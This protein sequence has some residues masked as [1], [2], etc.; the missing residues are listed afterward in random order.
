MET[1]IADFML[2]NAYLAA[3]R[4]ET[5]DTVYRLT[6]SKTVAKDFSYMDG[7][8][9]EWIENSY[10][11]IDTHYGSMDNFLKNTIGLSN[12]DIKQLRNAYLQ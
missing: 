4:Q 3:D 7:V 5:Y 9:R 1:I 2:T 11:T 8:S 12:K 6:R 10:A